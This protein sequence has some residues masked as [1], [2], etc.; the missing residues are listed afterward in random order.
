VP[1]VRA[2]WKEPITKSYTPNWH[3]PSCS[4]GY[5]K[6]KLDSLSFSETNDSR[7]A[8]EHEAWDPEWISYRFTALLTCNNDGCKEPVAV[9]GTGKVDLV[10]VSDQH[11]W[12]YVEFFYPDFINPAPALVTLPPDCPKAVSTELNKAFVL[13]W[14]DASAAANR[15]RV[16]VER[17]LDYLKEPKTKLNKGRRERLSLHARIM[18]LAKRDK[19]LS[20]S[21]LAVKWLGNAGSHADE[22]TKDDIY[23]ALDILEVI[24]GDLFFRHRNRVKKLVLA[25]NRNKGPVKK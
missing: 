8:H 3:C 13:T 10:Q 22:L 21:L 17:L 2:L 24:L 1:V 23:D 20:D 11:D 16:G 18:S 25:I 19:D 7:S 9:C 12:D 4:G 14:N 5:L 6:L 15:I